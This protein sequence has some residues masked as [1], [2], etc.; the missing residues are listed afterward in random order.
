MVLLSHSPNR[1]VG[2]RGDMGNCLGDEHTSI[3]SSID[4]KKENNY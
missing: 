4:A 3:A 1:N 2:L